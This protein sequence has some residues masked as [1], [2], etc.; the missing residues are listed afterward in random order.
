MHFKINIDSKVFNLHMLSSKIIKKENAR[1]CVKKHS[2]YA[3]D[4]CGIL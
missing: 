4:A 2:K 3:V 1:K